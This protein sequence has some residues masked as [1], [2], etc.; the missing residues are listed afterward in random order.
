ML[1]GCTIDENSK[2]NPDTY[3]KKRDEKL[4]SK[5]MTPKKPISKESKAQEQGGPPVFK[6]IF[7]VDTVT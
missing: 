2:A 4:D 3:K 7:R 1:Y 6:E 5:R